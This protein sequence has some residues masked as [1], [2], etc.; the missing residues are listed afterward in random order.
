MAVYYRCF[1]CVCLCVRSVWIRS[2]IF[3][4]VCF[5]DHMLMLSLPL[6]VWFLMSVG[7]VPAP[8]LGFIAPPVPVAG[9]LAGETRI[10]RVVSFFCHILIAA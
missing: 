2:G 10:Y 3:A 8:F 9:S 5:V 1:V 7:S 4:R 6:S